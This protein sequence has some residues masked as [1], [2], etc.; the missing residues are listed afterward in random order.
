MAFFAVGN[1]IF[2]SWHSVP[3][4]VKGPFGDISVNASNAEVCDRGWRGGAVS[5]LPLEDSSEEI[6]LAFIG[7]LFGGS[8]R[9][10]SQ[11]NEEGYRYHK[12]AVDQDNAEGHSVVTSRL[13]EE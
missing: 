1:G 7:G 11:I 12:L 8:G 9:G 13:C 5:V 6:Q 3:K 2:S 4:S 10:F